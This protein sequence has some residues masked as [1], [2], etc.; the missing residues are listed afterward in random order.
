LPGA[1][2]KLYAAV[3]GLTDPIKEMV[4]GAILVAPS[5]WEQ[6]LSA[7]PGTKG[8]GTGRLAGRSVPPLRTD[9]LALRIEIDDTV[10]EWLNALPSSTPVGLRALAAARW[11][12]QDT[13]DIDEIAARVESWAV[14]VQ[15]LLNPTSTKTISA[16]CPACGATHAFRRDSAGE[17]VRSP[18]LQIETQIGCTCQVCR[19]TWGPELYLHLA[20]V[21]GFETPPGVLE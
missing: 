13:R 5:L 3:S 1:L 18:A 17:R 2:D 16:P 11:R 7:I 6:L 15:S 14:A 21:L 9:A 8:E 19:H 20:R 10:R 12:P 4:D